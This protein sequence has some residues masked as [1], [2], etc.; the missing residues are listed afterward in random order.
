MDRVIYVGMTAA[1]HTMAQLAATTQNLANANTT[2]F[3]ADINMFSAIPASGPG[4]PTREYVVDSVVG[5]DMSHGAIMET[6]NPLDLAVTGQGWFTVQLP[7]GTE[8][9]TRNG[10]FRLDP[11]GQL[12][13]VSGLPVMGDSGPIT[14]PPNNKV[15]IAKDG[16]ISTVLGSLPNAVSVI[17]RIKLVNPPDQELMK[18][19]D[20]FFRLKNGKPAAAD[21]NVRVMPGALENSNVNM[22]ESMINMIDLGRAFDMQMKLLQSAD[23]N[24][25]KASILLNINA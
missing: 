15:T 22:I 5:A 23:S 2:G 14:I 4:N 25:S 3:K 18:G 11:N 10:S 12:Q 17:G 9:Y 24:A 16:T 8:A 21:A 7:D 13:T 19:A 1:K 20:N 6:G